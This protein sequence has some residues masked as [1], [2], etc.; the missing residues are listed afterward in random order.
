MLGAQLDALKN[1]TVLLPS[2]SV[3]TTRVVATSVQL[4][5]C[6]SASAISGMPLTAMSSDRVCPVM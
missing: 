6:R 3:R 1:V 4:P 2:V 5:E